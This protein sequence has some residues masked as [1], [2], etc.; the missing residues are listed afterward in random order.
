MAKKK[1]KV[2]PLKLWN[3]AKEIRQDYYKDYATIKER[4]G[5]RWTG[6][7]WAFDAL[8][9]GLG[10]DVVHITG[11]P[12][13]AS[14]AF[15]KEFSLKCLEAA[16]AKGWA[17]DLCAYMRNYWGSMYLN[18]YAF[19]G[20]YP[21]PDFAFQN[22][23]CCSHAK[24]YQHV[25]E[26]KKIPYFCVDV[27]V[28]PY[29]ELTENRLE[30]VVNQLHEAIEWLEKTT[31]RKYD[32]E[33]LFEAVNNECRATSAW[34]EVCCLNKNQPAPLEEKT[35]YSLYVL[36]TLKKHAK[37]VADFYETAAE[38]KTTAM[39]GMIGPL[40]TVGIALLVGFIA[41]SVIMP[42]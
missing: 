34:A 24:W 21:K 11:E 30:Y 40:S 6:G 13:G 28:G 31:G 33:K 9:A 14:C 20:E 18:K 1:Y 10:D 4:G 32:D 42:M 2:E 41:L 35:M 12:Y 25:A 39:V 23:I 36:G 38:E 5:L 3:K 8:P 7:A 29:H 37:V 17:R 16:E 22:H 15:Q 27:S 26:Y 19:G